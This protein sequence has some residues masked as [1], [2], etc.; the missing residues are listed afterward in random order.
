MEQEN[1]EETLPLWF[2]PL[3]WFMRRMPR[4]PRKLEYWWL[5]LFVGAGCGKYFDDPGLR[6]WPKQKTFTVRG[7]HGIKMVTGLTHWTTRWQFFRGSYYQEDIVF[8]FEK[9]IRRGDIV[10][11][12]GAN[13]GTLTSLAA[14]LT[15]PSGIVYA[16]EPNPKLIPRIE[17]II[18]LNQFKNVHLFDAGLSDRDGKAT[19]VAT[20]SIGLSWVSLAGIPETDNGYSVRLVRG[21]D[22]LCDLESSRPV[23]LK[24]DVEGHEIHALHGFSKLLERRELAVICEI[25]RD[26]LARAG[27]SPSDVISYMKTCGFTG[28][29]FE[30]HQTRWRRSLQLIP[31]EEPH[32]E[33]IYDGL[34]LKKETSLWNRLKHN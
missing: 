9:L 6:N 1:P 5:L 26:A 31:L 16:F 18:E 21:E 30:I 8:L 19:L 24:M 29:R 17:Q 15:G 11:D 22:V 23:I 20:P 13:I 4:G 7:R 33:D 14:R 10:I 3:G 28:F 32:S 25:N 2:E 27:S 12:A 34:F